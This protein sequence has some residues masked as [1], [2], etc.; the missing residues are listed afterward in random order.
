MEHKT[1]FKVGEIAWF[2]HDNKVH[3]EEVRGMNI[4][5]QMGWY[6]GTHSFGDDPSVE[7]ELGSSD[8][9][10]NLY[11]VYESKCFHSKKEL[12]ENF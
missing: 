4:S 8:W 12:L 7:L 10:R 1:K 11:H 2:L 9:G 3:S 5:Y 6:D